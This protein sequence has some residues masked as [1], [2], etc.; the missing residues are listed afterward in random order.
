MAK[1]LFMERNRQ[2]L[3]GILFIENTT[4]GKNLEPEQLMFIKKLHSS[5]DKASVADGGKNEA[6]EGKGSSVADGTKSTSQV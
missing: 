2:V 4:Y 1:D 6:D 5:S 3:L